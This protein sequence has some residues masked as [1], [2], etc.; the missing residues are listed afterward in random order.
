MFWIIPLIF[1]MSIIYVFLL[2]TLRLTGK[3]SIGD[4]TAFDFIIALVIGD[5][6]DDLIW[7]ERAFSEGA[8]GLIT[9][10]CLH[11]LLAFAG[12]RSRHLHYWI[13]SPRTLVIKDGKFTQEGLRRERTPEETVMSE[14]RLLGEDNL[15]EIGDAGWEANGQLSAIKRQEYQTM[16]KKDIREIDRKGK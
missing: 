14:L 16:Q 9:L 5:M 4:L 7:A 3:R 12:Y 11:I 1:R 2:V 8:V 6:V 10:L 15:E 13:A